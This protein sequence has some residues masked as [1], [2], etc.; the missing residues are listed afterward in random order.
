MKQQKTLLNAT[1][2]AV[3]VILCASLP[4]AASVLNFDSIATGGT[5]AQVP[6]GY[7]GFTWD[8]NAYVT[9]NTYYDTAYSNTTTFPSAPNALYNGFGVPTIT[10]SGSPFSFQGADVATFADANSE[11]GFS[12]TTITIDGYLSSV[13]VGTASMTL[14]TD[15]TFSFLNANFADVDTLTLSSSGN[16]E[17][18]LLDNFTY[19]GSSATPEPSSI[20][21]MGTGLIALGAIRKRARK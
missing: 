7:G 5:V 12:S 13:L 2:I 9:D 20:L 18:W 3:L 6:A 1:G 11:V 17:W 16:G 19:N 10:I 21:L 4:A 14:N 8:T 15:G